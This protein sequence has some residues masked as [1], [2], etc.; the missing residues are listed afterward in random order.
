MPRSRR[1]TT[2]ISTSRKR[3]PVFDVIIDDLDELGKVVLQHEINI[4]NMH[5]AELLQ[6][7]LKKQ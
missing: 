5:C 2:G 6:A 7:I 3:D 1:N 4:I